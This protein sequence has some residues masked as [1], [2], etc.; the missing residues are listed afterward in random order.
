MAHIHDINDRRME[1]VR[2]AS[3]AREQ[4]RAAEARCEALL[5]LNEKLE[6]E[7]KRLRGVNRRIRLAQGADRL[8][9]AA[10]IEV[11]RG[12]IDS[13]SAIGDALLDYLRVGQV[14]GPSSVPEWLDRY[15][16]EKKAAR[17][18]AN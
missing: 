17:S 10:A 16:E 6:A 14:D 12:A 3:R 11:Q 9:H 13:R 15:E 4:C 7:V 5:R 8:A 1:A 2:D 18:A